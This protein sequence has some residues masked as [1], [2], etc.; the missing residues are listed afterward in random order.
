MLVFNFLSYLFCAILLNLWNIWFNST[1]L[2]RFSVSSAVMRRFGAP[3]SPST[4]FWA[5]SCTLYF[6]SNFKVSNIFYDL[7]LIFLPL[8]FSFISWTYADCLSLTF[9]S[10]ILSAFS[11]VESNHSLTW[12]TTPPLA[13][14][15]SL[16]LNVLFY[17][18]SFLLLIF[19]LIWP[20]VSRSDSLSMP[21][22]NS[23]F[24]EM[25][26]F[27]YGLL[28]LLFA[29]CSCGSG[30]LGFGA[31]FCWSESNLVTM[32]CCIS[33][34]S[35]CDLKIVVASWLWSSKESVLSIRRWVVSWYVDILPNSPSGLVSERSVRA[36]CSIVRLRTWFSLDFGLVG[37]LLLI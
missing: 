26:V 14:F 16:T 19:S 17:I 5:P 28:W 21:S 4:T 7:Y 22:L 23:W 37:I 27:A 35:C 8:R 29:V 12:M 15:I 11:W 10:S 13:S 9:L 36:G 30:A 2:P 31:C 18:F 32:S 6:M 24:V 1:S 34:I 3:L 33:F 20:N 25:L